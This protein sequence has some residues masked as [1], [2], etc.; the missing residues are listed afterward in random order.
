MLA[1]GRGSRMSGEYAV[2][3]PLIKVKGKSLIWWSLQCFHELLT[4]GLI[5]KQD[6]KIAIL[7]QQIHDF[8][9]DEDLKKYF[10]DI[11]PFIEI[12]EMT[13]GPLETALTAVNSLLRN[14]Q[15]VPS[16]Q[17]V[18]SDS[19]HF[20][21]SIA[22]RRSLEKKEDLYLWETPKGP[23]LEWGFLNRSNSALQIVEK[24][25]SGE[26]LDTTK[27]VVGIYGFG[28][29]SVF[30]EYSQEV[31]TSPYSSERFMSDV[32]NRMLKNKLKAQVNEILEF[33]PMGTPSQIASA[34]KLPDP[35]FMILDSPNYF[36]DIDGVLLLHNESI[37]G[38]ETWTPDEPLPYNIAELN[39]CYKFAR[40]V[41]VTARPKSRLKEIITSLA[42]QSINYDEILTGCSGG[43]RV[44]VNDRKPRLPFLD[45]A[46][47][48]NIW[49]NE[50]MSLQKLSG[51]IEDISGGSGAKTF[52]F[53]YPSPKVVKITK[54]PQEAKILKYQAD[55][56]EFCT[57]NTKVQTLNVIERYDGDR[58]VY[59][60]ATDFK[61]NLLSFD[62][63]KNQS[64]I[65]EWSNVL[66]QGFRRLYEIDSGFAQNDRKLLSEIIK[67]KV[68]P[69]I[70]LTIAKSTRND[71]LTEELQK[72]S[73]KF[74]TFLKT[75]A[76][77]SME[78]KGKKSLIH[79][80]PTFENLQ[81]DIQTKELVFV[82]PV[83]K[84]IESGVPESEF[85]NHFS[86]PVFDLARLE[87]SFRLDYENHIKIS[88]N[89]GIEER[90][91]ISIGFSS[92][93]R[94]SIL[95][96]DVAG[97]FS[98]YNTDNLEI[99]LATTLA[100]I[101]KYKT[102]EKELLILTSQANRLMDNIS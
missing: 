3:K 33:I 35:E 45:T 72:L 61:S 76:A 37:H 59:G 16:E 44:L 99:V 38:Q 93:E 12:P 11:D 74:N 82:D 8:R 89:E 85:H 31:M 23:G 77:H 49:R 17:V 78:L 65:E 57:L 20:A 69:S 1:A 2:P 101:L 41:L 42:K 47:S 14:Q 51:H 54:K 46:V 80:D 63:F 84:M 53:N 62:A 67:E 79:G 87:L 9:S 28:A 70:V 81:V 83:G 50:L 92:V 102:N 10:G 56:Y 7:S 58:G 55:W 60:Y 100:R 86:Y 39:E 24:P 29:A 13:S 32:V 34:T 68:L 71:L 91:C 94:M 6:I 4:C 64:E 75:T 40:I 43:I 18:F 98:N 73:F 88:R 15:L 90:D 25:A 97:V 21:R 5:T 66:T 27:G 48:V 19:D 95:D 26:G 96:T 30:V 22:L 36:V 52:F